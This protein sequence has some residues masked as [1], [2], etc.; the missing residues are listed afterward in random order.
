MILSSNAQKLSDNLF[1]LGPEEMPSF[2][3]DGEMPAMFEAGM[4]VFSEHYIQ[5]VKK[6]LG[7]RPLRYLFLT[8]VHFDHC[9]AAGHIK[10]E[11]PDLTICASRAASEIIQKPSALATIKQLNSLPGM[12][13]AQSFKPFTV[14][15]TVKDGEIVT[16]S[17][18]T[19]IQA[20][21]VPG[22]TRDLTCYYLPEEKTLIPSEAL[23]SPDSGRY[24]HSEFLIDYDLYLDSLKR[25]S[26]IEANRL[27]MA[28]LFIYTDN[29]AREY[30]SKAIKQTQDF[31][32][33]IVSLIKQYQDDYTKVAEILKMEDYDNR[34]EP[35]LPEAAFMLNLNAKIKVVAKM[36]ASWPQ[37]SCSK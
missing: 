23:G 17:A 7:T 2:L 5:E 34:P 33:R 22:H 19:S 26:Q 36:M 31:K 18:N 27:L 21:S 28:H 15:K 3:L 30:F 14:D 1:S 13:D 37:D 35:K 29:D 32:N 16:L 24:I 20:I 10:Q 25:I 11:F 4:A 12:N 8:H 9:G 6:I